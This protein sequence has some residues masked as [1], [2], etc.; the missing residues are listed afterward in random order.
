[1]AFPAWFAAITTVPA[2]VSVGELPLSVA[3]PETREKVTAIPEVDVAPK[4][5]GGVPNVTPD[6]YDRVPDEK[7]IACDCWF[8]VSVT[9]AFAE[10]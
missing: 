5:R 10:M 8:T 9:L 4:T 1:M 6:A 7:L 3:G 2:P